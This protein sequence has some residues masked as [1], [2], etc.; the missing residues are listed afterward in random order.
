[1]ILHHS[2][3]TANF[4]ETFREFVVKNHMKQLYSL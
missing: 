1:M 4:T 3:Y 2:I